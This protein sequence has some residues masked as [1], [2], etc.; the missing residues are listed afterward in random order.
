MAKAK[1]DLAKEKWARKM[2]TTA[3]DNWKRGVTGKEDAY[4]RGVAEF[5]GVATCN[6]QRKEAWRLGVAAVSAE[7]FKAAVAGKE[8]KWKKRYIE[9]M[10]GG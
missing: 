9:K 4:C 2:T 1:I 10:A 6:P 8:E 3:P 5:I 7:D